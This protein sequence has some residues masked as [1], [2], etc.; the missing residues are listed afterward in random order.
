MLSTFFH[1]VCMCGRKVDGN[2]SEK[3]D[4]KRKVKRKKGRDKA[5][6]GK[7]K[8]RIKWKKEKEESGKKSANGIYFC[9]LNMH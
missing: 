8:D 3:R 9:G 4:K 2:S 6:L 1:T 5:R 7:K